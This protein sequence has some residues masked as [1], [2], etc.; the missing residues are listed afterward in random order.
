MQ[1]FVFKQGHPLH[2]GRQGYSS[3]FLDVKVVIK[4]SEILIGSFVSNK[5]LCLWRCNEQEYSPLFIPKNF[6]PETWEPHGNIQFWICFLFFF[7]S[8]NNHICTSPDEISP[9][10]VKRQGVT[11]GNWLIRR[12]EGVEWEVQRM[13]SLSHEVAVLP[14]SG[15]IIIFIIITTQTPLFFGSEEAK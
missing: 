6:P 14:L 3:L 10:S 11:Y 5:P 15:I 12:R 8:S 13:N 7:W 9:I 4:V 1:N 2:R